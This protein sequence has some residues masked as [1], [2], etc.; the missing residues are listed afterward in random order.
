MAKVYLSSTLLDL[1]EERQAVTDWLLA[2]G[3][4]PVHSYVAD[5][6]TVRDSCLAD[7]AGCE[8]YLLILGYRHGFVPPSENPEGLSITQLEFRHAGDRSIPRVA[9]LS[10][11]P[12]I[13]V[14][15]LLDPARNQCVQ[16]FH[17][18]VAK[19][20]WA[21]EFAD[22]A[23]LIAAV[24]TG[25]HCA[26]GKSPAESAR[27]SDLAQVL[28]M[29]SKRDADARRL[30]QRVAELETELQQSRESG[31]GRVLALAAQAGTEQEPDDLAQRA[32]A[33]LLKGDSALAEQV[34]RQQEDLAAGASEAKR[35]EAAELAREIAALAIGR[36]STAAL[37]ALERAAKYQPEDFWTLIRLGDARAVAGQSGGAMSSYRAAFTMAK[38]LAARDPA[39]TKWQRDLS[40]SHNRIGDVLV[41]QGDGPGALAAFRKGFAI[42][43]A[44]AARDPANTGWL[45]DLSV[46][47]DRI[48]DVLVAQGDGP[49]AL[50]AFRKSL[51]LREALAARDPANTEWQRDLSVSH[52]KIGNVLVAQGD[53][54]GALAAFRKSLALRE[55][56]AARD[57]ANTG[58]QVDLAV[59]CA[60]LGSLALLDKTERHGYLQRGL[61]ILHTLREADRLL[62]NQD[63]TKWFEQQLKAI[64]EAKSE[65]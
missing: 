35:R 3:H 34:L 54:P 7:I 30:E 41:A 49:G 28:D 20:L 56:L 44:L 40:V 36:D 52:E 13:H 45:R 59:S 14:T 43:E 25:V 58:W 39:N 23:D 21:S 38:A 19:A 8:L 53:G 62:P 47:H 26:L 42:G 55:A 18:E 50:A 46:S 4:Q 60:K 29:L 2:A 9:F 65:A 15:D 31:V 1:K 64:E 48:G 61:K 51:A 12:N 32:R 63:W 6:E 27:R 57:P 22:K 33:A 24:S 11:K 16:A 5:S 17:A 37:A 10:T